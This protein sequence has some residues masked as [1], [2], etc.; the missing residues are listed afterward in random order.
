MHSLRSAVYAFRVIAFTDAGYYLVVDN[1]RAGYHHVR[2]AADYWGL[3][4]FE[5][6]G[7]LYVFTCVPFGLSRA[8]Y[9]RKIRAL[10]HGAQSAH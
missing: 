8:P 5:I 1:L 3:L 9:K 4:G 2:L 10:R 6:E 7:E